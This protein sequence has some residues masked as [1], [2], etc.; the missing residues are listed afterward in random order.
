M[1]REDRED[2]IL[3]YLAEC[4]MALPL[5]PI[6]VNLK[7]DRDITFSQRTVKRR[8]ESLV[9]R[10][11]VEKL[12]IGNGYYVVSDRGR[13]YLRGERDASGPE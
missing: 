7:R 13:A 5:R 3:E 12:D 1:P 8:L 10:D 11:L 9:D 4:D 6:Y 2:L